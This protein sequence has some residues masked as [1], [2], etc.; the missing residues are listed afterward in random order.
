MD[1]VF[2]EYGLNKNS[3]HRVF[4]GIS[5]AVSNSIVHGNCGNKEKCVI[6]RV[7]L[8][9]NNLLVEVTDEGEGFAVDCINDP[10]CFENVMC[11]N[12]RGIFIIHQCADDV[13]YSDGG[14]SVMIKYN[15]D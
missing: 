6:I 2:T 12:G 11:E 8:N 4:L 3:F 14:R 10:T 1:E 7:V 15:L 5:E 9:D 13:K